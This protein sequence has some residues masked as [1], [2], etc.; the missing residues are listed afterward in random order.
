MDLDKDGNLRLFQGG[1][2][3]NGNATITGSVDV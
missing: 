1:L 2:T 3:V